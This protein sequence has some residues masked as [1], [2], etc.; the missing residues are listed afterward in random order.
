MMTPPMAVCSAL[1]LAVVAALGAAENV[2]DAI[3]NDGELSSFYQL[4]ER[5]KLFVAYSES[6]D[7]TCFAPT[8]D[9]IDRF[10]ESYPNKP[11]EVTYHVVSLNLAEDNLPSSVP[12]IAKGSPH[13]YLTRA[14]D[15]FFF[16]NNAKVTRRRE[17][18]FE[19][20][21]QKLYVID[22]VLEA[23]IPT[24]GVTPNA[25]EFLNQPSIYNLNQRLVFF[26]SRVQM[27]YEQSLFT[28]DGMHT[29]FV[30]VDD[31]DPAKRTRV[32]ID[33][34]VVRGHVIK[35]RRLFTRTMGNETYES[36]AWEDNAVKVE[37]SLANQSDSAGAEYTLFA[38]SNTMSTE[39]QRQK[40]VVLSKIVKPNIPV[41]NG[42]VHLIEKP[43]M[44][45][46]TSI[47]DFFHRERHGRLEDFMRLVDY[48][49]DF[50]MDL[51]GTQPKTVFAPT[52]EALKVIPASV[53]DTLKANTSGLTQLLRLHMIKNEAVASDEVLDAGRTGIFERESASSRRMLYMRVVEGEH[54]RTLTVEGGGV[55]ATAV[56]A[57]IGATNGVIHI[58]DRVLGMPSHT[59][60]EKISSDPELKDTRRFAQHKG[61]IERLKN[62]DKRYTFF[63]PS[64]NA[65]H[66][67]KLEFPSEYKQLSMDQFGYHAEKILERHLIVGREIPQMELENLKSI[68]TARG[69]MDVRNVNGKIHLL[70]EGREAVVVRPDVQATN[71]VIHV[72][73]KVMMLRR[74]MTSAAAAP[75]TPVA[76][77]LLGL[78]AGLVL[79]TPRA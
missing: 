61:W 23:F 48:S 50:L 2:L 51:D 27:T 75:A 35:N 77:L 28:E 9:A 21:K 18:T 43:L 55:N 74:D 45:V 78:A 26:H 24:S 13:L 58:I 79:R 66:D 38:Q 53:L 63:A 4:A 1:L 64:D 8:N 29:F 39:P 3:R 44:V 41:K 12:T 37:L 30:P 22:D 6:T 25:F 14:R 10:R 59:I 68:E 40:G 33:K 47:K 20:Y 67:I 42:V 73:S 76:V 72:I 70:W 71:G 7:I 52:N 16:V 69:K 49:P 65:W 57:D 34:Y 5:V 54:G 62:T 36:A 15:R 31:A 46:D 32:E 19:Q 60:Y 56:Q 11:I 17:L